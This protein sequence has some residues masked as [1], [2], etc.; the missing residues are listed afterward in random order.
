MHCVST[1]SVLTC[2]DILDTCDYGAELFQNRIEIAACCVE[3]PYVVE[4][5]TD[6]CVCGLLLE[7]CSRNGCSGFYNTAF[8]GLVLRRPLCSSVHGSLVVV[9]VAR[10][11]DKRV[12][13]V[14]GVVARDERSSDERRTVSF[15]RA[16]AY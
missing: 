16:A 15:G 1:G 10:E 6:G 11:V 9:Y 3:R 5:P 13:S 7:R 8:N 4:V 14:T 2:V 12:R